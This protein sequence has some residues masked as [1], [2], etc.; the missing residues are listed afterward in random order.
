MKMKGEWHNHPRFGRQFKVSSHRIV[1]PATVQGI[2][3]YLGSGLVKGIGPVMASRIVKKF[4]EKT[5]EVM[6]GHVG[7]PNLRVKADSETWVKF[8]A[9]ERNMVW[10]MVRG[11]IRI[12]GSPAR[13]KAFARCFPS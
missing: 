2:Q 7:K 9:K 4:G 1:L 11:K 13:L 12:K 5:L 10:A 3:K 6:E 8:L